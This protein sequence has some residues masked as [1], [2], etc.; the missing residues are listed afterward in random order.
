[1]YGW[2]SGYSTWLPGTL[3]TRYSSI[4]GCLAAWATWING[5]L[6]IKL[7]E[8]VENCWDEWH[9]DWPWIEY[10]IEYNRWFHFS[11]HTCG[12]PLGPTVSA[13]WLLQPRVEIS[14]S[15]VWVPWLHLNPMVY[16]SATTNFQTVPRCEK[17]SGSTSASEIRCGH[18]ES[19]GSS[20]DSLLESNGESLIFARCQNA[21]SP[22]VA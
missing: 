10:T 7:Q 6:V 16:W 22:R 3:C 19:F 20:R 8:L 21:M 18:R 1:M 15:T 9:M 2:G 17:C 11:L 4:G 13:C 12:A 5:M 14:I